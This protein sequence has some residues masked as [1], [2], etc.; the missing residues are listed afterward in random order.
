VETKHKSIPLE[1]IMKSLYHHLKANNHFTKAAH[2]SKNSLKDITFLGVS[3]VAA[4]HTYSKIATATIQTNVAIKLSK[5]LSGTTHVLEPYGSIVNKLAHN[6]IDHP[7]SW[8]AGITATKF[9]TAK[10]ADYATGGSKDSNFAESLFSPVMNPCY[11]LYHTSMGLYHNLKAHQSKG[12]SEENY[13]F[14]FN[15]DNKLVDQKI[16]ASDKGNN[17]ND[18]T[19]K[20]ERL[21][22]E[23]EQAEQVESYIG[24]GSVYELL[25]MSKTK[26]T[27]TLGILNDYTD[28]TLLSKGVEV[29]TIGCDAT[30]YIEEI[31]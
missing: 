28:W 24:S 16:E 6:L 14:E 25:S 30:N 10:V 27:V 26:Y 17:D 23:E 4:P 31:E 13:G 18:D 2:Y 15:I 5:F 3:M 12:K 11:T 19:L 1:N 29:D 8:L 21:Y 22:I 9:T 20:F 7:V